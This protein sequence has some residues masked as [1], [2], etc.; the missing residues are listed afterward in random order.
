MA[1]GPTTTENVQLRCAMHNR[2]EA[3]LFYD[4]KAHAPGHALAP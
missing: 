2:Y 1:G 3:G 4:W